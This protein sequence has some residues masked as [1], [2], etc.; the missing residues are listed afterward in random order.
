MSLAAVF[1]IGSLGD[2]I[3]SVP[4]IRSIRDLLPDCSEY[5]LVSRFDTAVKV[6]PSQVFDMAW[7]SKHQIK[8]FG[9]NYFKKWRRGWGQALSWG[10]LL[11]QLRYYRPRY[12]VYLMPSERTERQV[13]RDRRF[14]QA[15]GVRELAGFRALSEEELAPSRNPGVHNT[16]AYLR[17]RRVWGESAAEKFPQYSVAPLLHPD[18][19]A[20]TTA[21]EWLRAQRRLPSRPL[22]AVCPYSNVPSRS[23]LEETI[24]EVLRRLASE[25]GVEPLIL[26]GAKDKIH[27]D[28][29]ISSTGIG[30]NGCGVFSPE[31]SAA[32]LQACKLVVCVESGPMHLAGALGVPSVVVY[33]R[34][35][36]QLHRWFPLGHNHTIL[37]RDVPCAG[38]AYDVCPVAGHPCVDGIT[39][40]EILSAVKGKLQGLPVFAGHMNGTHALHWKA[41]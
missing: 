5:L 24:H 18:Q 30:L 12:C 21:T 16:E 38:C 9:P 28:R 15:A 10:F 37:Y 33:S 35:T 25:A 20:R 17:F 26:G 2:S 41:H 1:Q 3:V 32:V 13:A 29:A 14:F 6:S 11:S 40:T 4:V 31:E 19:S 39:A 22:V 34:I 7:K 23:L 8:Y 36:P 27:A